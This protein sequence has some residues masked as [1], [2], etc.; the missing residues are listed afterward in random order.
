MLE[1]GNDAPTILALLLKPEI[2]EN[3]LEEKLYTCNDLFCFTKTR[4][5]IEQNGKIKIL[6]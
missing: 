2:K 1:S 3:N 5:N 4:T 6:Y